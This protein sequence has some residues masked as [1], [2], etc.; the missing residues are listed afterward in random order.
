MKIP[1]RTTSK[2][3][4]ANRRNSKMSS[5]P[6]TERGRAVVG[7]NAIK[8]G[9]YVQDVVIMRGDGQENIIHYKSI[10][11][12]FKDHFAPVGEFEE[13]LVDRITQD[14]WRLRR[15]A[16]SE[17]GAIRK[18]QDNAALQAEITRIDD[19]AIQLKMLPWQGE[20]LLRSSTGIEYV[21]RLLESAINEIRSMGGVSKATVDQIG[22]YCDEKQILK[23]F[24]LRDGDA[25]E[26]LSQDAQ[27][28]M[29]SEL[30]SALQR[31]ERRKQQLLELRELLQE[32]EKLDLE[33]NL[34]YNSLP[35]ES[36]IERLL[37]AESKIRKDL[38]WALKTLHES[39]A[40]R[41]RTA[42]LPTAEA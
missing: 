41:K 30:A 20:Q 33:A 7:H 28:G 32:K 5:G 6:R 42:K 14:I 11:R 4:E 21:I 36:D 31:I 37:R 16:R 17:M 40:A 13:W 1:K 12:G 29:N 24:L 3:I 23:R 8:H 2:K 38:D 22:Q 35:P 25:T 19:I 9:L 15:A 26:H 39:Q 34:A 27:Q 18:S 10:R